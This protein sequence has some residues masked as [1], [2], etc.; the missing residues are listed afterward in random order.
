MN[1]P[2]NKKSRGAYLKELFLYDNE[3]HNVTTLA[4]LFVTLIFFGTVQ[5]FLLQSL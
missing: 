2:E 4:I 3:N 5:Q 1:A